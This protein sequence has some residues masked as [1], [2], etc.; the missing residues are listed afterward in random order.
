MQLVFYYLLKYSRDCFNVCLLHFLINPF[1][2]NHG[3]QTPM[4][5]A[6]GIPVW[7][8]YTEILIRYMLKV[9]NETGDELSQMSPF[10][11]FREN[12]QVYFSKLIKIPM[13]ILNKYSDDTFFRPFLK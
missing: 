9:L 1:Y 2:M 10:Y 6:P 3:S 12:F 4:S 7:R 5:S 13:K 11:E 8:N